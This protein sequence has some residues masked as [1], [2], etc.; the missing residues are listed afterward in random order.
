MLRYV[1][2]KYSYTHCMF[3]NRIHVFNNIWI[4]NTLRVPPLLAY[5]ILPRFT[6][7]SISRIYSLSSG[8]SELVLHSTAQHP[9]K[10]VTTCVRHLDARVARRKELEEQDDCGYDE[11]SFS[12]AESVASVGEEAAA[13]GEGGA[14]KGDHGEGEGIQGDPSGSSKPIVD[15]DLK[16]AF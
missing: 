13:K 6:L 16:V 4:C 1:I 12:D 2:L 8:L 14:L 7:N 11:D 9:T 10:P 15:I 3:P 5:Y